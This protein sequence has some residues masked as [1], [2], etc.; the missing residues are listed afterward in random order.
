MLYTLVTRI[1]YAAIRVAAFFN[2]KASLWV[3]GRK[4][5]FEKLRTAFASRSSGEKTVWMHCASLGE[6]EQGRTL[7]EALRRERPEVKILLTFF[8]PSG[9]ELRRNSPLADVVAYLPADT[10]DNVRRFLDIVQPQLVIFVKY[11]F[12]YG[13][14]SALKKRQIPLVLVAAVFRKN[15]PFFQWYGSLHRRMLDCF[16]QIFVQNETSVRLLNGVTQTPVILAGDTRIDRV[17]AIAA[18]D[19][20]YPL[21]GQFC[22]NAPVLV[23]GSTWPE[24]EKLLEQALSKERLKGWKLIIAPHDVQQS[25]IR[26]LEQRFKAKC[27]LYSEAENADTAEWLTRPVLI[28]DSIGML[29]WLYRYGRIACIGG[30]FGKGIHNTLEPLAFGLPVIFGPRYRKFEEANY[31]VQSGGGFSIKNGS[32]LVAV[33]QQLQDGTT[34]RQTAAIAREYL[35]RNRGATERVIK[36]LLLFLKE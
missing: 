24:D 19:R 15:Q 34:Y 36:E 2:K 6:F 32:E 9:Y 14:L 26:S 10:P 12:W 18:Q 17:Q 20:S 16:T 27:T 30:G 1:Y 4:D 11:E 13:Y 22:G 21:I 5:V 23:A 31:L 7:L 25:R 8:S 33:L 3:K 28:I 35:F 29:A